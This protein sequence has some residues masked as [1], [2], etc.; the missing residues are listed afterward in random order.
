MTIIEMKEQDNSNFNINHDDSTF[1]TFLNHPSYTDDFLSIPV[2]L[3]PVEGMFPDD[4]HQT[5]TTT[6]G[7]DLSPPIVKYSGDSHMNLMSIKLSPLTRNPRSIEAL[8]Q[9]SS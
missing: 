3:V 6:T 4:L 1:S 7:T 9:L 5:T 2:T 8:A